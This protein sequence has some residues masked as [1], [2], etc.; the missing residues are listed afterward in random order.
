MTK[1]HRRLAALGMLLTAPAFAAAQ[2][3]APG[4]GEPGQV[5][6]GAI[7]ETE[8]EAANTLDVHGLV[9]A[10]FTTHYI[11]RGLVLEDQGVIG[12]PY[13]EVGFTLFEDETATVGK[14]TLFGGVWSSIHSE[15]TDE[16]LVNGGAPSTAAA[17]YEF[18]WYAGF[19]VDFLEAFNL[20]VSYWEFISPNQGFGTSHNLQFKLTYDDARHW[21]ESG[22]ALKPYGIVFF[23]LD[24]KAGSGSDE[25]IYFEVGAE[26]TVFTANEEGTY[27]VTLSVP[28]KVGLGTSDFYEDDENF[29]FASVGLKA[30]IPL[31]FV[32]AEYGAWSAYAG[33]YY[34]HY[35]E[36]TDDFNE[37][38]GDGDDDVVA[39]GGVSM[40]F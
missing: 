27:P 15:H 1:L 33:I 12:Q 10:D 19:A 13:G 18:D 36:G 21:G 39:A 32:P 16:G 40:S 8:V 17:W 26:P 11:S 23:E 6:P 31:A 24:G 37:G 29:G 4:V 22:F 2:T 38:T 25:G 30:G 35:G 9:G 14:G 20:N 28:V 34:Y 3:P 7:A 5:E